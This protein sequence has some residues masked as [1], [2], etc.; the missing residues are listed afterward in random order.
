MQPKNGVIVVRKRQFTRFYFLI[1][2]FRSRD[3]AHEGEVVLTKFPDDFSTPKQRFDFSAVEQVKGHLKKFV[4]F[5][6]KRAFFRKTE[7]DV[8][9]IHEVRIRLN[10]RKIWI[11][12]QIKRKIPNRIPDI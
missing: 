8:G 7:W 4:S 5:E 12:G 11:E 10:L 1:R 3:G 6:E 2:V 9:E